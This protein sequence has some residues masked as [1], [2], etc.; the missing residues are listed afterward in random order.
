MHTKI[1]TVTSKGKVTAKSYGDTVITANVSGKK[2]KCKLSVCEPCFCDSKYQWVESNWTMKVGETY[3]LRLAWATPKSYSSNLASIAS[4]N[5]K[6]IV[7]AKKSG[8]ATITVK[9]TLNRKIDMKI[10]VQKKGTKKIAPTAVQKKRMH[11]SQYVS[12]DKLVKNNH[13]DKTI[14]TDNIV[15][16]TKLKSIDNKKGL[17]S[18]RKRVL[19]VMFINEK[20]FRTTHENRSN[21]LYICR[22]YQIRYSLSYQQIYQ[23]N[24]YSHVYKE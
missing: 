12:Y 1:A 20:S 13:Y 18:K 15:K 22:E 9:D 11:N 23:R 17:A 21:E 14:I 10:V 6:G 7:T 4:V 2:Y 5:K 3:R 8:V 16:K 24:L 19:F